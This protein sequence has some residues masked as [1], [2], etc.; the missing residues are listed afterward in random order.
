M[1]NMVRS[2]YKEVKDRFGR[3]YFLLCIVAE[4]L[5]FTSSFIWNFDVIPIM[6]VTIPIVYFIGFLASFFGNRRCLTC[7][8]KMSRVSSAD[9]VVHYCD[10]CKT[11][12]TL[13][14][15]HGSE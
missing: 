6:V 5:V 15:K 12:M 4:I 14:G 2:E 11:K 1:R 3:S 7:K 8:E 10:I 13:T 9:K